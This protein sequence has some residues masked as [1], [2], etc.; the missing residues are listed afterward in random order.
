MAIVQVIDT[1]KSPVPA[2]LTVWLRSVD[3]TVY[4]IISSPS[5]YVLH[6]VF[7]KFVIA[8]CMLYGL[9][10]QDKELSRLTGWLIWGQVIVVILLWLIISGVLM[11]QLVRRGLIRHIWTPVILLPLLLLLEANVQTTY[12][13]TG[14]P[15]KPLSVTLSDLARIMAVILLFD[16]LHGQYVVTRHPHARLPGKSFAAADDL[17]TASPSPPTSSEWTG[18]MDAAAAHDKGGLDIVSPPP[19]LFLS[20]G[21][22][23]FLPSRPVSIRIGTETFGLSDI[24]MIRIEDH[25]LRITTRSGNSL[26][27]AKLVAIEELHQGDLGIQINRSVWVAFSAIQEV[28][29]IRNGQ[30]RLVLVNGE[31]ELVAK[32]RVFAF[33]QSYRLSRGESIP[34]TA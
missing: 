23:G 24:L 22:Q 30:I 13:F 10:D 20:G 16:F 33:R 9:L 32:P 25:Y 1:G 12:F 8:A 11:R 2:D 14:L 3:G 4:G 21:P 5:D 19:K 27:R 31:E 28:K 6:P 7:L 34:T 29:S 26:Q 18:R 17:P 15:P